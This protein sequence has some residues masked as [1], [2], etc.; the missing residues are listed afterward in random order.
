MVEDFGSKSL[1]HAMYNDGG[2]LLLG[3]NGRVMKIIAACNEDQIQN[4]CLSTW[5]R[6]SYLYRIF[7]HNLRYSEIEISLIL[8]FV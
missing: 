5:N 6:I 2:T 8:M 7:L 1:N 4:S 3:G